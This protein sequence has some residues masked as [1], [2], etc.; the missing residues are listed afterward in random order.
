MRKRVLFIIGCLDSGGV[1]KSL[2]TLMNVIDKRKYDIHLLILSSVQGPF[3]QYLPTDITIHRDERIAGLVDGKAGLIPLLRKGYI[4]LFFCSLIRMLISQYDK[5]Y[6]GLLLAKLMPKLDLG[7]FDVVVD[8]GGQHLL[9][10]MVDK[11]CGSK[12]ISYF[13]NDYEKWNYYY[14]VDKEYLKKVNRIVLVSETCKHSMMR[15]FP[16]LSDKMCVIENI[17]SP[18]LLQRQSLMEVPEALFFQE[19]FV[20]IS[21]GYVCERK[22]FDFIVEAAKILKNRGVRYKWV[23]IGA[24]DESSLMRVKEDKLDDVVLFYGIRSN[25]YPYVRM[26]KIF[27]HPARFEG[28][29][30]VVCEAKVLCKPIVATNFSTVGDVLQDNVN[31]SI[32]EMNAVSLASKIEELVQNQELRDRYAAYHRSHMVDN[33]NE[34]DKLYSMFES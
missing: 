16:D 9:Y 32:C 13:H 30:M 17:F 6:S 2:V 21:V 29:P 3:V 26:S 34:V 5:A 12:L 7:E 18:D 31:A 14:R 25:P 23:L 8:Y 27:V 33:S 1:A 24:Y 15:Y 28:K 19:N 4:W 11:L 20:I 10:Y 22:G